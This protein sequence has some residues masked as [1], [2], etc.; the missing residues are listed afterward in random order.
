VPGSEGVKADDPS[1]ARSQRCPWS[2][3]PGGRRTYSPG[4]LTVGLREGADR[5][6]TDGG[7]EHMQGHRERL[8]TGRG[9]QVT[10]VVL[11]L[12]GA[13]VFAASAVSAGFDLGEDLE[14]GS[15]VHDFDHGPTAAWVAAAV[16]AILAGLAV[17]EPARASRWSWRTGIA[18]LVL[19]VLVLAVLA[20]LDRDR[21]DEVGLDV[22]P[23]VVAFFTVPVLIISAILRPPPSPDARRP[24]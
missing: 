21:Y 11:L 10:G 23:F 24:S 9:A 2:G 15:A 20:A 16:L 17:V 7:E 14:L 3:V 4:F 12:A 6:Q 22:V 13:A 1:R 18:A 5:A 19:T 8:D